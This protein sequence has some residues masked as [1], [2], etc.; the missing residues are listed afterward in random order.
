MAS[1]SHRRICKLIS[2][3]RTSE[4]VQS[5]TDSLVHYQILQ[6]I[7]NHGHAPNM[8]QLSD[9]CNISYS[10]TLSSIKRLEEGHGV[11]LHPNSD[12]PKIWIIH[13]FSLTPSLFWVESTDINHQNK[14]FW[15]PCIWC[16][17]GAAHLIGGNANIY[18]KLGGQ[19]EN[20]VITIKNDKIISNSLC[21]KQLYGHF[22]ISVL[23]AWDNVHHFCSI[24]LVFKSKENI[25]TWCKKHGYDENYGHVTEIENIY[26]LGKIWYGKHMDRN[27]VKWTIKEAKEIFTKTGFTHSI[28]KL[29]DGDDTF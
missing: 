28:W 15:A 26:N 1:S 10:E 29:P 5:D 16:A 24:A 11:V 6:Y 19:K 27:W 17:C 13:P 3:L 4:C 21:I 7:S 8:K 23:N 2:Q 22:G 20:I 9:K 12:P 14:G 18:T 25:K